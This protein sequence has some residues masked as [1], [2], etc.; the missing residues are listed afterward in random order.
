MPG[1]SFLITAQ[2]FFYKSVNK[3]IK[4]R[5]TEM[6][7]KAI[8]V[9]LQKEGD[10][11]LVPWDPFKNLMTLQDRMNRLFDETMHKGAEPDLMQAGAWV[12]AVDIYETEDAITL[13]AELPGM[14]QEDVEIQVRE[15]TLTLKGERRM[16]KHGKPGKPEKPEKPEKEETYHRLERAYGVFSRSFTLPGSVENNNITA[17][18][19]KG[20]LEIK[21]PKS[22]KSKPQQ[23]KIDVK[24]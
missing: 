12:P 24:E 23:I 7:N 11:V 19:N 6:E 20:L 10:M 2:I 18:F 17:T 8:P 15:N 9:W 4:Y 16:E 5:I 21:M 1:D 22:P 14:S 13:V 3:V